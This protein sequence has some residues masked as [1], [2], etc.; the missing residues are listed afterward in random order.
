M[1]LRA[2]SMALPAMLPDVSTTKVMSLAAITPRSS[3]V[4][5]TTLRKNVPSWASGRNASSEKASRPAAGVMNRRK[6]LSGRVSRAE[7]LTV[8]RPGAGRSIVTGWVG[9]WTAASAAGE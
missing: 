2:C 1:A 8:A 4:S 7:Y 6:S 3:W 5:G 9:Q